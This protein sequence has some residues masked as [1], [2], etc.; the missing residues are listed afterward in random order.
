MAGTR[1]QISEAVFN[2]FVDGIVG[3][4]KELVTIQDGAVRKIAEQLG[5]S[6]KN[7][8]FVDAV[9]SDAICWTERNAFLQGFSIG[10]DF[11]N[12]RIVK[13]E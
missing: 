3:D 5:L 11:M 2:L 12:G 6:N 7:K 1:E 10:V 9:I 13:E 4:A 8:S